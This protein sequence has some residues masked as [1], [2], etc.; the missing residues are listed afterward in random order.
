MV[1]IIKNRVRMPELSVEERIK[2]FDEVPLGYSGEQAMNEA[3]RCLQCNDS[4]CTKNC[5]VN[6]DVNGFI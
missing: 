1:K 4:P 3:K 2:T 6:V 5:P